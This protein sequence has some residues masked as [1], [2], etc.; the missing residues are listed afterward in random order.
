MC[1][2]W[3]NKIWGG[4]GKNGSWGRELVRGVVMLERS[5]LVG[6]IWGRTKR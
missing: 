3:E 5:E 1:V 4:Q 2:G 6:A